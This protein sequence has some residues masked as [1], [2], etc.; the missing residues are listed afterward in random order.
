[1]DI[2]FKS[3][4]PKQQRKA[5]VAKSADWLIM[6]KKWRS[7]L[8]LA[9]DETEIPGDDEDT[10]SPRNNR[11]MRR[12]GRGSS[13]KSAIDWLPDN[14]AISSDES[15]SDA[16]RLAVLLINKQLKRG[17]WNE[18]LTAL[19]NSIRENCLSNGVDPVWQTLGQKTA[20][21][22]Q[23]VVFPTAKKKS[24]STKKIDISIGRIDVFNHQELAD[25][26]EKL[27]PLCTDANQQ[28]AIQKVLSQISAKRTLEVS[29]DLLKLTGNA[30]II[31]VILAIA[32]DNDAE[33]S[34]KQLAKKNKALADE[35]ED[36]TSLM[37]GE[38]NDWKSSTSADDNGLAK[39][40]LRYAWL[41][42]PES[43][44]DLSPEEI[45][46]GIEILEAIPN[47]Q[48]Q[49]HNLRWLYLSA[50]A[51]SGKGQEAADLLISNTLDH[52]IEIEKL[53]DLVCTLSIEE[54]EY[55]LIDQLQSLD[56]G[57]LQYIA[58]HQKTSLNL[59]NECFK[60]IQDIGGEGW[61]ESSIQAVEIF[62][63]KLELRR[64]SKILSSNDLSPISH[65]Y[66]ALLSYHILATNSEQDLWEKFVEIRRLA[67][68]SIHSTEPP[69]YLSPMSQSLIMLMEGNKADDEPFTVLPKKA[70]Q[71]LKQ[72][73]NALK[74]GGTGIASRTHIE[75]LQS[76][77]EKAKF[78]SL[79][80]N[81]FSVLISTLKLNQATISLQHGEADDEIFNTLNQLVVGSEI[82]TRLIR[83]IKQLVFEH[84]IGLEKLVTWYQQNNPLSPWH[85]LSR[86]ALFA[87]NNDE[88]NAAREYRRVAESGEFDFEQSM[89]LYRK[90]IIHL[91][92]AEQWSEAVDLLDNQPALRTAITK[93]FQLYLRV[94]FTA[95][96]QKTNEATQL[97]K[98]FVRRSKQ[99]EEENLEGEMVQ[100][101]ITFF[102]EDELESLRNYP[103]EHSRELPSEPFSGRVTAALNSVQRNKRRT[104][105][106][107][108]SRFRN[109]MLQSQP[110]IMALYDIARDSADKNPIEGLMYLERAQNSG[111]FTTS[112]MKRLYD[113]ERSLFATHKKEIPNSSRRYLKNLALPPLIIVDTNILVDALVDKIAHNLE[114]AS[115]T[116]LDSFE[117][118]N[119]HKVL[120]SRADAGRINLWLPSIVK[121]EII[122][123][124][125]R[126][127]KLKA[128]FQ[129]SLVKPE[130]LDS[131]FDDKK[132]GQLVDEIIQEFNRWKPYDIHLENEAKED[133]NANEVAE[134]LGEYL[135]IYEE[136]TEMKVA[137]DPKQ[138]R[139]KIGNS[140]VFPE[141][142]DREIMSIVKL[143]AAQSL[144]GL[145][146]ILVATRDGDFT[147]TARAFEERFGYAIIKNSKML[148]SW[149]N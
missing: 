111:K 122:E 36:L 119:F 77:V 80:K 33:G 88:L 100:K 35:F 38:I 82:P 66:E 124:S 18:D 24:K 20:L 134:F 3:N 17:E 141:A 28:I 84:D 47:S 31:S 56:E 93:R 71:A 34:I 123:L 74:Q 115:E 63:Q 116:S 144:E 30:S 48:T 69:H 23:F 67:L 27:S 107:F 2:A 140:K 11:M 58:N 39:A 135:E 14:D 54:V 53:Y 41:N 15:E 78:S 83:S 99:L 55:W 138:N 147:L 105:H 10:N 19:E 145:G 21:L 44:S 96:N 61:E 57:A 114:L 120:L 43:V 42:F 65:P 104:R 139:T 50:L 113:A 26:I 102:A 87:Q 129:S 62:A 132:I 60:L 32:S 133:E 29:K 51:K 49:L 46:N 45:A 5:K 149:L 146:S 70:Y 1:M 79:E 64:L 118:D 12:R 136:L 97:L 128:K 137:R 68:T 95:S 25:A 121:H 108:D 130:I 81:L 37:K 73:R 7:I 59:K 110:S 85:T 117:H 143:L 131:V 112:E 126:H 109:E 101:T 89:V 86:A 76:S 4:I 72:A 91:A 16:F 106:G 103:F 22:A 90:S 92:H 125:K 142:A 6:D 9:L 148:N 8:T 40:R 13:P 52:S 98:D 94:S 127:N 75:H